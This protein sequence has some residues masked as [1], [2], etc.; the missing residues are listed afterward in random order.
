MSID[1]RQTSRGVAYDVRLRA[2]DGRA[3]KRTFKTRKEAETFQATE[4][5]NQSRGEWVDPRA[6]KITLEAFATTWIA[7]RPDLRPRTR[8]LYAWLLGKHVLPHLGSALVGSLRPSDVRTWHAN[9]LKAGVGSVTVAK[10]YRLLRTVLGTAV[11]D[12]MLTKNPCNIRA[13][14]IEHSPERPTATVAQVDALADAVGER[15]RALVLL[16]A[17]SGLR[18]GELLALRRERLDLVSGVVHVTEGEH[19]LVG[20]RIIT[21]PPKTEAGYR[22]VAVPPHLF[23]VLHEHLDRFVGPGADALVFGGEKGGWLR[24]SYWN[25]KWRDARNAVG[26]PGFRFHDLRHTGNT[27]A[28]ATGASTRELMSRLGHSSPRAALRYQH[29]TAERDRGIANALSELAEA[30]RR[31]TEKTTTDGTECVTDVSRCAMNVPSLPGSDTADVAKIGPDQGTKRSGR[32][33]SNSHSQLGR[34]SGGSL[35]AWDNSPFRWSDAI[36]SN[37]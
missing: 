1:R 14:G 25:V 36:F 10:A 19:E 2:P 30:G 5:T 12:G 22:Q 16:A 18:L 31:D 8:D 15:H 3:Y 11:S 23:P 13:G 27:L 6:G 4:I 37:R 20:G 7:E 29:A 32:R 24:R 26:M 9:L 28:A 21:G 33:G 34:L 35:A 17:Y